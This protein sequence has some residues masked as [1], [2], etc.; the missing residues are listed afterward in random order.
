MTLETLVDYCMKK[1]GTEDTFPFGPDVLVFKVM[2]KMYALTNLTDENLRVNLKCEPERAI[3]LRDE[4]EEIIPG[5]HMSKKHWNTVI[6][7][8]GYLDE[9]FIKELIDDSYDLIVASLPKKT[10]EELEKLK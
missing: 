8:S 10:R 2:N 1:P 5:Y 4:Y 9:K 3:E 7:G 6:I